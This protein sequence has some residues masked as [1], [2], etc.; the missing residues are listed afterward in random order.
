MG[1]SRRDF[2][3]RV[4]QAGGYGA[5]FTM[6]QSLGLLPVTASAASIIQQPTGSG[7]GTSVV[8]L[9]GG[10]AGLASAYEL[11]NLGY[12]CTLL[13]A[14]ERVGGRNWT[15]R[16]GTRVEFKDGFVQ[17]CVFGPGLYQN[18]GPARLPSVHQTMLGYCKKLGVPLEVEVNSSRSAYLQCDSLNGG[19]PVKNRQVEYDTRG[20]VSELLAKC[21]KRG[22]LDQELSPD[23]KEQMV[24]FLREYGALSPDLFYKGTSRA[25]WKVKPG[26]GDAAGVPND[27][28]DM[29]ALLSAHLWR[30]L[31]EEDEID[32][33]AT[34]FQP[35]GGMDQIPMAFKKDLGS[36][37]RQQAE[38]MQIRQNASGVRIV[39]RDLRTGKHETVSADYCICAL[40][41][42]ILK[43][44]DND[45][46]P[47]L[48]AAIDGCSY[49]S[50]YKI[51]WESRRFW[52]QECN[53]YG[54]L[55][56]L[57]QTV[58]TVWYPSAGLFS[59]TGII[60]GGYGIENG[61]AFGNLPTPE[62]KLAASRHSI[63]LLH[64]GRSQELKNPIYVSWGQIPYNLG[65][66]V[67]GFETGSPAGYEVWIQPQ[68]RIYLAGDHT[69]YIVGWQEG[70]ALSAHRAVNQIA[71]R[72]A[73]T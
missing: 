24:A 62:A 39:Y 18:V 71:G 35:V 55:S 43:T 11:R 1:L 56:F 4:G 49:D 2:L 29:R 40:P 20:H 16:N 41:L 61:S 23:D 46:S 47:E 10:I 44:M 60:L 3:M 14:R 63:E 45:F 7:K 19:K 5:A 57:R 17:N 66:W 27:P 32:W 50:A 31:M 68:G 12:T 33:Q 59:E 26:A 69:S 53:I 70:A 30:E 13:E 52:E 58:E 64:P 54:G 6:M 42:T 65:S 9:G 37:I 51:A 73:K 25:G 34:M 15:V 8:I 22:G 38:V 48:K 28:L 72:V 21:I 36:V 67:S